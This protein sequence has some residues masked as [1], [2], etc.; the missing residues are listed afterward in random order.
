[1]KNNERE[2]NIYEKKEGESPAAESAAEISETQSVIA[3]EDIALAREEITQKIIHE[4]IPAEKWTDVTEEVLKKYPQLEV[5]KDYFLKTVEESKKMVRLTNQL[6]ETTVQDK[7]EADEEDSKTLFKAVFGESAEGAVK[8]MKGRQC[9]A[10]EV[11]EPDFN[12]IEPI[13]RETKGITGVLSKAKEGQIPAIVFLSELSPESRGITLAH[14]NQ[15]LQNYLLGLAKRYIA[16]ELG[17]SGIPKELMPKELKRTQR[18]NFEEIFSDAQRKAG[19]EILSYAT[20][21]EFL[22]K[23]IAGIKEHWAEAP[24]FEA[25]AFWGSVRRELTQGSYYEQHKEKRLNL[26]DYEKNVSAAIDAFVHLTKIYK[27]AFPGET[28]RMAID[29]LAQFPLAK[30]PGVVSLIE[31]R[32]KSR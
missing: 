17:D 11:T 9:L 10:F 4:D 12:K 29:V 32:R 24:R 14:E 1:M 15:H 28:N 30:W 20:L 31:R 23:V 16:F 8:A 27:K 26:D 7:S 25:E 22:E 2:P 13:A 18:R 19:D 5:Y 21:A 6:W 3:A